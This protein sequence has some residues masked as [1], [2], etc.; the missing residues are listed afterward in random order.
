[1]YAVTL[2]A[3]KGGTGK[4]TLAINLAVAAEAAGLRT[5][6]VDLDPQASAAGWGDHRESDRRQLR[7][8]RGP[9]SRR[10]E[11]GPAAGTAA[12]AGCGSHHR[13]RCW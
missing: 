2:I 3:H 12:G 9:G 7:A 10:A 11:P 1:M 5:A 4:T 13:T 8:A 6:L